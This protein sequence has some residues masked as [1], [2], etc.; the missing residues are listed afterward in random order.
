MRLYQHHR[1]HDLNEKP[2]GREERPAQF[3]TTAK[4]LDLQSKVAYG[5]NVQMNWQ[6]KALSTIVH[7][8]VHSCAQHSARAQHYA[9]LCTALST[10]VHS[11]VHVDSIL[12]NFA[13][14]C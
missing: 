11:T 13:Q 10:V 14:H 1:R 9:Q 3:W 8:T 5:T 12:N 4:E 6:S 2:A 7:S